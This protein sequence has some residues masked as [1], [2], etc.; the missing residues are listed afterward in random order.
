MQNVID[1]VAIGAANLDQGVDTLR[2]LVGV[3][4][5]RGGKHPDMSTHNCVTRVG[6]GHFLELIAIDPD[7]PD[8]GRRRWFTLDDPATQTRLRERPRALCWVVGTD[9]L[10]GLV[11]R[12]PIDLGE[13]LHL[14]RGDLNWRLTVPADGSLHEAGL[15]PAFIEW[16]RGP[17]PSAAMQDVG[18]RLKAIRLSHPDPAGLGA[19]LEALQVAHLVEVSEADAP[20]LSFVVA[21][22]DGRTV[23]LD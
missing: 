23:E 9:D 3:E 6:D 11:A 22:A 5:P 2:G 18:L 15:L 1:H 20:S 16:S 12:S 14:S 10:D 4:I 7:A 21:T 19:K 8:P 17:H 13:I